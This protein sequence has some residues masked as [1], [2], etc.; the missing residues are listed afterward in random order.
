MPRV[1]A[2]SAS[3]PSL[4]PGPVLTIGNFDGVHQGHQYLISAVVER[5][6]ALSAPACVYTFDPPPRV[7][8]APDRHQPRIQPWTDRVQDLGRLGVDEVIIE[9]F[10]RAFAQHPP[11]WFVEEIL[12]RRIRPRAMVV[13]YDFRFGRDRSGDA[14]FLRR[15]LG[16]AEIYQVS[17][18]ELASGVVSS[19]RIREAVETG[20]VREA[21]ELLGRPHSVRGVVRQGD[22]RGRKLGFPTANVHTAAELLPDVGVYA[23]RARI[24]GAEWKSG[25][26]NLGTRPTFGGQGLSLEVHLLDYSDDLYGRE[27][28]VAFVQRLRGEHRFESADELVDQIRRDEVLARALLID[29]GGLS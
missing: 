25:V 21:A 2:G 6:Q 4:A 13:G 29:G 18:H 27:L 19:S 17:P 8:L 11:E 20:R 3:Y 9:R 28:E 12:G 16:G 7:V 10:T 5:A 22:G 14:D 26:A 23:V 15:H 24:D 1:F